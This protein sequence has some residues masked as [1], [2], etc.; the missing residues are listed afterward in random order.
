MGIAR[1][2][3]SSSVWLEA[4]EQGMARPA[5]QRALLLLGSAF[6]AE[7]PALLA[8]YSIGQRNALLLTLREGLFGSRFAGVATCPRCDQRLE[9]DF[10]TN[11]IRASPPDEP[12]E[13]LT[14]DVAGYAVRFRLPNS[15]DL[16]AL[17]DNGDPEAIQRALLA[18]CLLSAQRGGEEVSAEAL[19]ADVMEALAE[20]M[21]QAD[22]Q[23]NIVFSL[24]C[25]ACGHGWQTVLD[26]P[27]YLW[28]EL[29]AWARRALREVH[30]L[31]SAY[32]WSERDILNMRP[33]RRRV[34]MEMIGQ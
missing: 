8:S 16:A 12:P 34:Y 18:R 19:P 26:V 15:E 9:L 11:D 27:A 1:E 29:D 7:S 13:S 21:E 4:W 6:P 20:A 5:A 25:P 33:W 31:A 23:A 17:T 22:P 28:G 24:T 2:A 32:G 14:L 10:E 30:Y 3:W